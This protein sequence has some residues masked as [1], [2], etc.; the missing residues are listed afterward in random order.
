ML[1]KVYDKAL[2]YVG[3]KEVPGVE[4]NQTVVGWLECFAKNI[5]SW[6]QSRDETAWCAVFVSMVLHE[7]GYRGTDDARAASYLKWGKPSKLDKGCVVVIKRQGGGQ[8]NRTGSRAGYHV[9]FLNRVTKN[10]IV[11][12]GG[13]QS[14]SVRVSYF[15]R[16]RYDIIAL[17]KPAEE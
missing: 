11:I 12:L 1:D 3:T 15:P 8:D 2:E 16:A 10:Y 17:R 13:N 14:D 4:H 6:G 7:C 9:G 5:G